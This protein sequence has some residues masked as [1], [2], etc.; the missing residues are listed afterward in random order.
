M[1]MPLHTALPLIANKQIK[2]LAIASPKWS[3]L[4]RD[5]PTN[6]EARLNGASVGLRYGL[7]APTDTPKTV[8]D[9]YND[10]INKILVSLR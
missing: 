7:L 8:V 2:A 9:H 6:T 10:L 3:S 5:I 1:F 4:A